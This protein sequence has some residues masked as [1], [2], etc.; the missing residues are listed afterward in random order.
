MIG[1]TLYGRYAIRSRIARGGMAMVYLAHDLRLE[2]RVAVKVMHAHL[3]EDENFTR[4]FEQ[5]ARS[6][7]GLSHA[8]LVSVLD[9]GH[10]AGRTY[11]VMEYLPSITLR[12]LLKQQKRL[13]TE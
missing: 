7:A 2:R 10:D 6:A 13:T 9:Q 4:R 5:E 8:N 3:A 11:L 12:D 1:Q